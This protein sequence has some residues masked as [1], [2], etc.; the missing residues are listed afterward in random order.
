MKTMETDVLVIGA[1]PAGATAAALLQREQIPVLV[2][3]KE[4]FPR[5]V[6]GE[7]LLPCSMD[8]LAH[9]GLLPAVEK[10]Q[11]MTKHGAVFLRGE[12]RCN[13]DFADQFSSGWTYTYQVPRADFDQALIEAVAERGVEVLFQHR[14]TAVEFSPR[15]AHATIEHHGEEIAVQAKFILDCSGYGRVLPRL[16]DLEAPSSQRE[17]AALFTHIAGDQRP[18]EREEG[19]IWVCVH[20]QGAW[21]WIIPFSNGSTSL[22][23]VATP[24]FFQ[25]Y[26]EEPEAQLRAI[27]LSDPNAAQRLG[28]MKFLFPPRRIQGYSCAVKRLFGERF[29]LVGNAS[30]FLDP[31][32]SSGVALAMASA[33]RAAQLLVRQSR[34]EVAD[35]QTDYADWLLQGVNTFRSYIN[36]WYSGDLPTIFFA[37]D[38]HREIMVQICSVLAGYVWDRSNPY[39]TKADR[40]ITALARILSSTRAPAKP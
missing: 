28:H 38:P 35:W 36:G 6:I 22:G 8:V 18:L 16:L 34:G 21:I 23:V 5:F 14:V 30:E 26:P 15:H 7:S 25:A 17:R 4:T 24:E 39:A 40:A 31:L 9:A 32:F 10:R 1:G 3:E 37:P 13:F 19:K 11:F 12:Q 33:E 20:P 29:A 27:V 2:V